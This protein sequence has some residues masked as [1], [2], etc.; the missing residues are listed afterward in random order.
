MLPSSNSVEGVWKYR[1]RVELCN[2]RCPQLAALRPVLRRT[3]ERLRHKRSVL[4]G[5]YAACGYH[6]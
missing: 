2:V 6:V 1:K 4:L 3:R 5:W